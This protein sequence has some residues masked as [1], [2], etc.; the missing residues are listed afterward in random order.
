MTGAYDDWIGWGDEGRVVRGPMQ[1]A[2]MMNLATHAANRTIRRVSYRGRTPLLC[3][4]PVAIEAH[5]GLDLRGRVE[6][7]RCPLP[8]RADHPMGFRDRFVMPGVSHRTKDTRYR[9]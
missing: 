6:G 1:A 4:T 5:G 2:G 3:G 9:L 7:H 8:V